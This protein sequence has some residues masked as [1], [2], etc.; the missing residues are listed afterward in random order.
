[1][2]RSPPNAKPVPIPYISE[3]RTHGCMCTAVKSSSAIVRTA[4]VTVGVGARA[5]SFAEGVG[6]G[7]GV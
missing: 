5:Y 4:S 7:V 3:P 2:S 1:M 6:G